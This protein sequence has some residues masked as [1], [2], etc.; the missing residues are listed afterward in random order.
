MVGGPMPTRFGER[1]AVAERAGRSGHDEANSVCEVALR[2]SSVRNRSV[3]LQVIFYRVA[4]FVCGRGAHRLN[5]SANRAG[6]RL[7]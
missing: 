1:F 2:S 5:I 4:P 7:T 3:W 6:Y